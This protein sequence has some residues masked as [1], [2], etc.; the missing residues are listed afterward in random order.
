MIFIKYKDFG[1]WI[2]K[3]KDWRVLYV[4]SLWFL[5]WFGEDCDS[6]I[7]YSGLFQCNGG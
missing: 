3:I 4:S 7:I 5:V 2:L 6:Y 1:D